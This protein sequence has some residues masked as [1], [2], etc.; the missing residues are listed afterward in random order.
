MVTRRERGRGKGQKGIH[1]TEQILQSAFIVYI[2]FRHQFKRS[3]IL[4]RPARDV[5]VDK[6]IGKTNE[7][8]L[9]VTAAGG[10]ICHYATVLLWLTLK[11]VHIDGSLINEW[12]SRC[13]LSANPMKPTFSIVSICYSVWGLWPGVV[14]ALWL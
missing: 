14:T 11:A 1:S 12:I 6:Q 2:I 5:I 8:A 4:C 7:L 9:W 13:F 3:M 10:I